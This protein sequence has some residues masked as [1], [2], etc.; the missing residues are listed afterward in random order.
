MT[1]TLD[2]SSM[3]I[4]AKGATIAAKTGADWQKIQC[5]QECLNP[6]NVK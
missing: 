2:V 3:E 5:Y 4:G 6:F 1:N